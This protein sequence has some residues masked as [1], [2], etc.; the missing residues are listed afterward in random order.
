MVREAVANIPKLA[1]LDILL[2][3]IERLLF[4]NLHLSVG[5]AGNLDD[6]VENSITLVSEEW[7]I[8]ERRHDVSILFDE[9]TMFW[10]VPI[11]QQSLKR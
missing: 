6:H 11:D 1:L 4:G 3:G 8:M 7:N 9:D 2:D 10:S 5:P